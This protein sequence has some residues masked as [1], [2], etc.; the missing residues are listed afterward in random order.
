[1][2][3]IGAVDEITIYKVKDK[4]LYL[5]GL[6]VTPKG[7]KLYFAECPR[8]TCDLYAMPL[9]TGI[10][11]KIVRNAVSPAAVSPNGGRIAFL[12]APSKDG[13]W[14]VVVAD[15]DGSNEQ[16]VC[17][18]LMPLEYSDDSFMSW[19][20]DGR[21]LAVGARRGVAG[22]LAIIDLTSN[23]ELVI[24]PRGWQGATGN[25]AWLPDGSGIVLQAWT[26]GTSQLWL[27]KLPEG[28][29]RRLTY[30]AVN[31]TNASISA[32]GQTILS[33]QI[34]MSRS[35]WIG[36]Y[37]DPMKVHQV[38]DSPKALQGEYGITWTAEGKIIYGSEE[39][40]NRELWLLDPQSAVKQRLTEDPAFDASPRASRDGRYIFFA[41]WKPEGRNIWRMD[42][43]GRNPR[44][45]TNSGNAGFLQ[46][47]HDGRTILFI[48]SGTKSRLWRILSDGG[49][50]E[51]VVNTDARP[52]VFF[53]DDDRLIGFFSQ[54]REPGETVIIDAQSGTRL[55]SIEGLTRGFAPGR[56]SLLF[57]GSY[58]G[59]NNLMVRPLDGRAPY[60]LT[61]F[62][63]NGVADFAVSLDGKKLA[64]VRFS[65]DTDVVAITGFRNAGAP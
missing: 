7:D 46:V 25:T 39:A 54:E 20:P 18:R 26:D 30:D 34:E 17:R 64:L 2:R 57:I 45:M 5:Y 51:M 32:D 22:E 10:P 21:S 15:A 9:P 37:K 8:E 23:T 3:K 59:V 14:D 43:D 49:K 4:L 52:P 41:K 63:D 31:Y 50:T 36:E 47:S 65:D 48:T 27:V 1:M 53:S 40:G 11:R 56:K 19:S 6:S 60:P 62:R 44:P 61:Q 35:I 42:A 58:N 29:A 28:T 33:T 12:R 16:V 13:T 38:S 55:R 24:P